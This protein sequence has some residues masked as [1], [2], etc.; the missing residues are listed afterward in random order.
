MTSAADLRHGTDDVGACLFPTAIG[1]VGIAWSRSGVR[2][3]Q[4]PERTDSATVARLRRSAPG[5]VI[6]DPPASVS[7][8]IRRITAVLEGQRD[9]LADVELD[10]AGVGDFERRVYELARRVPPGA[11]TTYGELARLTGAPG[12]ARAVGRAMGRNPFPIVVPCHR[13]LA[14]GGRPG[15]FSANGGVDTKRRMLIIEG[16]PGL[17]EPTLF[18]QPG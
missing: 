13:V 18:D 14:A 4:L 1:R 9:D 8:V 15:G 10:W 7:P 12:A 11:T 16:A 5:A 2:A 6:A 17:G 3:V